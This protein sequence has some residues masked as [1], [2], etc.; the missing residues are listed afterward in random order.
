[1]EACKFNESSPHLQTPTSRAGRIGRARGHSGGARTTTTTTT[2]AAIVSG[3]GKTRKQMTHFRRSAF[4]TCQQRRRQR[5]PTGLYRTSADGLI[6]RPRPIHRRLTLLP[7]PK[8]MTRNRQK[9]QTF[10]HTYIRLFPLNRIK[11]GKAVN[12]GAT[13]NRKSNVAA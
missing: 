1:M 7:I 10:F 5:T 2:A 12:C 8:S 3:D 13:S 4:H 6:K 11:W 9:P